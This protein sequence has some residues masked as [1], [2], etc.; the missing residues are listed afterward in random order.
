MTEAATEDAL[1]GGRVRL[2]QPATGYRAAIDPVL[3][4]AAVPAAAGETVLDVGAGAGAAA[5]CLA[6]RVEGCRVFG[7]EIQ[8]DLVRL[9]GENAALNACAGRVDIM[10]GDLTRVP[11]R[12]AAG[13]FDHVMAN[14]PFHE[15]G[16]TDPSPDPGKAA[17]SVESA[18][19]L[20]DWV[21]FCL[22]MVRQHGS[23]TFVHRADRLDALLAL[24]SPGAG[25]IVVFPLWPDAAGARPA[26]R[27]V[28]QARKGMATPL[29]L[30][31]GLALHADG[32]GYSARAEAILRDGAALEL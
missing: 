27:V 26:K 4:A 25:A 13:T 10:L 18:G 16:R 22:K 30:A 17:A 12:L 29:R 31:R 24:L 19:G 5:L 32:G 9:A 21:A 8:R 15:A 7:I 3:L 14:P 20:A 28:V 1:L 6:A 2:R 11:P 23:V